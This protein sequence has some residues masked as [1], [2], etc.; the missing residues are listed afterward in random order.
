MPCDERHVSDI[1]PDDIEQ[2]IGC[3]L[4]RYVWESNDGDDDDDDDGSDDD[5]DDSDEDDDGNDDDDS[6]DD[7]DESFTC[8][9]LWAAYISDDITT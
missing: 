4:V 6:H 5:D 9:Y 1:G 7:S 8:S 2:V 3:I